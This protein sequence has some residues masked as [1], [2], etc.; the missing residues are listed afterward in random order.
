MIDANGGLPLVNLAMNMSVFLVVEYDK[1]NTPVGVHLMP[2]EVEGNIKLDELIK[3]NSGRRLVLSGPWQLC[4]SVD[5]QGR[6]RI[7]W[8]ESSR[9]NVFIANDW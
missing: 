1:G 4:E 7:L 3:T 9:S 2:S 5:L 8:E 6:E